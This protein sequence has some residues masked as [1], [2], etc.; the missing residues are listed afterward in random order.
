MRNAQSH[1]F[2]A[3]LLLL[4]FVTIAAPCRA[5]VGPFDRDLARTMLNS[6]RDDV[7]K[8]Y[9]DVSLRGLPAERFIDAEGRIK[10]AKTRDELIITIAQVFLDLND[11]HTFF[12]PPFRRG[13]R[14]LW[15]GDA[16]VWRRLL[17]C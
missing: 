5:Q 7:K 8:N 9:Y 2:A 17:R 10:A 14:S 3:P 11:S 13:A 12:L 1:K 16:N 6:V 4:L 15:M